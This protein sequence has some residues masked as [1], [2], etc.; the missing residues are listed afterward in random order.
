M[1]DGNWK[2]LESTDEL[3]K[4]YF[5]NDYSAM[6]GEARDRAV[7]NNTLAA[8]DELHEALAEVPSWKPWSREVGMIDRE[9]FKGEIVDAMHFIANLLLV[10]RI[11][12]EE[13]WEAYR[14]KQQ[15]NRD[16]MSKSGGYQA[17][18]NK[19]PDCKRE[20]DKPGAYDHIGQWYKEEQ[21]FDAGNAIDVRRYV[22]H[23]LRCSGCDLEF[24]YETE[25]DESLPGAAGIGSP[26]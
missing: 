23:K 5:S 16:R 24:I 14:A 1:T 9:A 6:E 17:S 18:R 25:S 11:S 13:F 20:L 22:E 3:Q 15:R 7:V 2:W 8:L 12:E 4:D 26:S 19:C 10:A 21:V